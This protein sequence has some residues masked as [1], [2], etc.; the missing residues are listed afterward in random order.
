MSI[1]KSMKVI[2]SAATLCSI[3]VFSSF[4]SVNASGYDRAFD[5][6]RQAGEHRMK[7]M[8]KVLALSEQQQVQIKVIRTEAKG[9]YKSLRD[10]MKQF[11]KETKVLVQRETF[12]EQAFIALQ[13]VYKPSFEQ[14][15]LAKTKTKHAIFNVLTIKQQNKWSEIMA[16]RKATFN[17]N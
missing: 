11:R 4:S 7:R 15:G 9:Q 1:T 5:S 16:K 14:A 6:P 8:V 2:A 3:M 17:K 13:E 10:S 12:D